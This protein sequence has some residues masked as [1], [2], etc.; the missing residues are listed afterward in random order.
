MQKIA[1]IVLL[2]ISFS[3][4]EKKANKIS[5]VSNRDGNSEIYVMN[6]DGS[7]VQ[8]LS[9]NEEMDFAPA[10]T[11]ENDHI[12]FYSGRDKNSEVYSMRADGSNPIRMTN[13]L[14]KDVL[15]VPSPDGKL[16]AFMSDRDTLSRNLYVMNADGSDVRSLTQNTAYE[17]SPSWSPDGTKLLF[18]RQLRDPNDTTHAANGEIHLIS[19]ED[20]E[21]TRVTN[22]EGYDSGAEFSPDGRKIAF[23]GLNNDLWDL[24]IMNADGSGLF[25]LTSDSIECYSPSWSSDGMWLVYTAGQ[26]GVY[27]IWKI[28]IETKERI[29]LTDTKGRN[30][31][32]DWS[33]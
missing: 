19:L 23:Y 9:N 26:K 27:D 2:L 5:F 22:K 25:N 7:D 30:E 6:A 14:A 4:S 18:T 28:N 29:Q 24:F 1:P 21:V 16:I 15:P 33:N 13:H 8:N 32:P 20:S 10:W 17:E 12:Y 31:A 11:A 3:C